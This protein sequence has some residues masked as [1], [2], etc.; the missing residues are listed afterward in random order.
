MRARQAF[1]RSTDVTEPARNR[2][3]ASASV[4][5][6]NVSVVLV[7]TV[8]TLDR[9]I[10]AGETARA[11]RVAAAAAPRMEA[12]NARRDKSRIRLSTIH[13][14]ELRVRRQGG[15]LLSFRT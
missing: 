10:C 11:V 9:D 15:I 7:R 4:S 8:A 13:L 14:Y 6:V 3:D 1:T 2:A 12:V 5:P